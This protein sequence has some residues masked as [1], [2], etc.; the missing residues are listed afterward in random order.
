MSY[1]DLLRQRAQTDGDRRAFIYLMDGESDER[2]VTNRDMDDAARRMAIMLQSKLEQGSRVLLAYPF[3]PDFTEAFFGCLYAGMI[4][5]P[6]PASN[7]D[8]DAA[9]IRAAATDCG[10]SLA[11][12]A[13]EFEEPLRAVFADEGM[14]GLI[15]VPG[16]PWPKGEY[17]QPEIADE[18]I[19]FL[20]YTSGSTSAPKGVMVSH[21]AFMDNLKLC[22]EV[23]DLGPDSG[24]VSWLPHFFDMALVAAIALGPYSNCPVVQMAP[25][26]FVQRP[27]RWMHAMSRYGCTMTLAPNFAFE[28]CLATIT[29]E[30]RDQLDLSRWNSAICG[31]ERVNPET[32]ERF[33]SFFAPCGLRIDTMNPAYGLAETTLAVAVSRMYEPPVFFRVDAE[34]FGKHRI[35]PA[36]EGAENTRRIS[37]LG[38]IPATW[39]VRVVDPDTGR[40][41]AEDEIGELWMRGKGLASGYWNKPDKTAETFNNYLDETGEGP[42]LRT[43]D[44]GAVYQGQ[45]IVIGR[46]KDVIVIRGFNHYAQD[47][48]NSLKSAAPEL[49]KIPCAAFAVQEES[50]DVLVVALE[51]EAEEGLD[52]EGVKALAERQAALIR[53]TISR[54]HGIVP[55]AVVFTGP[56]GIPRTGSGKVQRVHCQKAYQEGRLS[57][58]VESKLK[59]PVQEEGETRRPEPSEH[60]A[61]EIRQFLRERIGRYLGVDAEDI[62]PQIPFR[63][64]G[65]DSTAAVRLTGEV[66][67]FAKCAVEPRII[68]EYPTI[69][70]LARHLAGEA[71]AEGRRATA[72]PHGQ[73]DEP[74]AVVGMACRFPGAPD[75]DAYWD[76]LRNGVDA[77]DETPAERWDLEAVYDPTPSTPGKMHT[78]WGGFIRGAEEFDA[79]FF[80]MAPAEA[81]G[82]DPQQR[83]M[84]ETAWAA[85]EHAGI[86]ADSLKG[87]NTGVFVGIGPV[88]YM[89]LQV[90]AG[91]PNDAFSAVGVSPAIASNRLSYTLGV[92]GPSLSLDTACSSGLTTVH[93]AMTSLR[94]GECQTAIAGAVN[95]LLAPFA[96]VRLS[97]AGMLSPTGRC[98]TFDAGADGYVRGEGCGVVVLKR[99]S[100]ALADGDRICAVLKGSAVNHSGSTNGI[101]APNSEA[102]IAVM[103]GAMAEAG[104]EADDIDYVEAH[105]TGT[106]LGDPI[107]FASIR[108]SVL[109]SR[110]NGAPCRIGSVKTN[111]GHLE[112]AAGMAGLIKTVLAMEHEAIPPHLHLTNVNEMIDLEASRA[113]IPQKLENWP[114][115]EKP[116]RACVNAFGFGGTN[117]SVVVEEGVA[118]AAAPESPVQ[119]D[120]GLLVLSGQTPQALQGQAAQY[121]DWLEAHPEQPLADV[122]ATASAGRAHFAHRLAALAEEGE[123]GCQSLASRLRQAA[124][125]GAPDACVFGRTGPEAP[126]PPVF[127]YTG[128]GAQFPAMGRRLFETEP[129]FRAHLVRCD[130]ILTPLLGES[131]LDA[132]FDEESERI[133]ETRLAQPALTAL[134]CALAE[135]WSSW[136]IEPAAVLGHSVGELAA[137]HKAGAFS[138]EDALRVAAERGRLLQELPEGGAMAAIF[139]P[140]D[141][142]EAALQQSSDVVL[143]A[144]NGPNLQVVSG[145]AERVDAV[146]AEFEERDVRTKR[147]R[148][149]HAFHS[150]LMDPALEEFETFVRGIEANPLQLPFYS[151]VLGRRLEPGETLGADYWRNNIRQPVQFMA[152]LQ[153]AL[154]AGTEDFLEIG[155][156]AVLTGMARHAAGDD[157]AR[158]TPSLHRGTDENTSALLALGALYAAGHGV[159]WRALHPQG[160]RVALPA[161]PFQRQRF[162]LE[163]G[164][165]DARTFGIPGITAEEGGTPAAG[166]Q[167][168]ERLL[169]MLVRTEWKPCEDRKDD[170]RPAVWIVSS[171]DAES[172]KALASALEARGQAAATLTLAKESDVAEVDLACQWPDAPDGAPRRLVYLSAPEKVDAAYTGE[173]RVLL[174]LLKRAVEEEQN[175]FSVC[176]ATHEAHAA[177]DGDQPRPQERALWGLA[178]TALLENPA[179]IY[180][181]ADGDGDMAGLAEAL[182]L[183]AADVM[184]AVRGGTVLTA[185]LERF[186]PTPHAAFRGKTDGA[187]LVTGGFGA[188]G[189][190]TAQWLVR[191]GARRLILMGR[192]GL[193]ERAVWA[194]IPEDD[195]LRKRLDAVLALE[196]MG[197]AVHIAQVDASDAEALTEWLRQYQRE[198]H[199]PV[200]G[201]FHLAGVLEDSS[202]EKMVPESFDRVFAPKVLG[203]ANLAE[204]FRGSDIDA[205]VLYSSAAALLG[206]A[207]QGNYA[208]ANA[209]LDGFAHQ[210]RAKGVPAVSIAWGPWGEAGMAASASRL[211]R[212]E[213]IG[214]HAL[215]PEEATA[216]MSL[217]LGTPNA[218]HVGVVDADWQRLAEDFQPSAPFLRDLQNSGV[219]SR[220][221]G[222]AQRILRADSAERIPLILD[223]LRGYISRTIGAAAEE[224]PVDRSAEALGIDSLTA[225]DIM[226]QVSRDIR[227]SISSHELFKHPTLS[228]FARY[229]NE[230]IAVSDPSD[231][232]GETMES[233]KAHLQDKVV[234]SFSPSAPIKK[235]NPRAVFILSAPRSG[236]TLLRAMLSAHP[237][238]LAPPEL[239]MLWFNDM[240]ERERAF[241]GT[242]GEAGLGMGLTRAMVELNGDKGRAQVQDWIEQ[243]VGILDAYRMLQEAAAPRLLVD[244]SP[245]YTINIDVLRRAEAAF[246]DPLYL[247]LYRHPYASIQSMKQRRIWNWFDVSGYSYQALSEFIWMNDNLN[248]LEFLNQIPQ[249]RQVR[250]SYE[251]L[252][253]EPEAWMREAC[254]LVGIDFE[255][256]MLFPYECGTMLDAKGAGS[257][258][259]AGDVNFNKHTSIEADLAER[260]RESVPEHPLS[261]EAQEIAGLLGYELPVLAGDSAASASGPAQSKIEEEVL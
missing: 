185:R 163:Y 157:A 83:V 196:K 156:D 210:L 97:Q 128:Q 69:D 70:A 36:P 29:P 10:A 51:L 15:L 86:A 131:F 211:S 17:R 237:A 56:Q 34:A 190:E 52:D 132:L 107:E 7:I 256:G 176:L 133:H 158:W 250:F 35:V 99:L 92:Q 233:M 200:R 141:E 40:L 88:D 121:A 24:I 68:Y 64:L 119:R 214:L 22:R 105:G 160:R 127:M 202:L 42:F 258:I 135:L 46:M 120:K 27:F 123:S 33:A 220:G 13:P 205:F 126:E 5:V 136:G 204:A 168:R 130:E 72:G 81:A 251:E 8:A 231:A 79:A 115:A 85:L 26:H 50:R 230:E 76:L 114:R 252:V 261:P 244:K 37:G 21:G 139:A 241:K 43:G 100:D 215:D 3:G 30:E 138:L 206:A 207:G 53:E 118:P 117:A 173:C 171:P 1:I 2:I 142:V 38:P 73:L 47:I 193:P 12:C 28:L 151:T 194:N 102:Q 80:R 164:R 172:A 94:R 116:R 84:L 11:L 197:A 109:S 247:Y 226:R 225:M 221:N 236:S 213:R 209:W 31:G 208:A 6:V 14:E 18:D 95:L 110:G 125:G 174:A 155:P 154:E 44:L 246:E 20:Q 259:V 57:A 228:D 96:T 144:H 90:L 184:R 62:D 192:R 239:H 148:V 255:E 48:E 45:L 189:L 66:A 180:A 245:S 199:P 137:A 74:V 182:A 188:L 101:T 257:G 183:S 65:L 218:A 179:S 89:T 140:H 198:Q 71:P 145:T 227:L 9:R 217:I 113:V 195:P 78:R 39:D 16:E 212:M 242:L 166:P 19:A 63:S 54:D 186:E 191:R 75:L 82:T 153:Q 169:Q 248:C 23:N 104:V 224:I 222:H 77:I 25:A 91:A 203:A 170:G 234:P 150:P 240:A 59:T 175:P 103:Q 229:L 223:L 216:C 98:R 181:M 93:E 55:E 159:D 238:L 201:V 134:E 149:S 106:P 243:G 178:R 61:A 41:C 152:G 249:K 162:W 124:E 161:Y 60:S 165:E 129:I 67:A 143:A 219:E 146:M 177:T 111:I 49:A 112:T 254:A 253:R 58:V 235:R 4:A 167:D 187:Y 147:M 87:S 32:M 260:W 232:A 108:E 122:C